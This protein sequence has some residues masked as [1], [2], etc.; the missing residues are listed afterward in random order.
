[1]THI[2]TRTAAASL[3]LASLI[4]WSCADNGPCEW[5]E[6]ASFEAEIKSIG[7]SSVG[8]DGDSLYDVLLAF[9]TGSLSKENQSLNELKKIE[10]DKDFLNRNKLQE[11]LFLTG[12]ITDL[13]RGKCES[14]IVSFDQKLR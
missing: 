10:I 8:S 7:F 4:V 13:K 12:K 11:G 9:N 6:E 2:L 14:P 1:M 3:T 5:E